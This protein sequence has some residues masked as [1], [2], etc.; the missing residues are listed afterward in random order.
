MCKFDL[1]EKCHTQ[2]EWRQLPVRPFDNSAKPMCDRSVKA[3]NSIYLKPS[4]Q[5]HILTYDSADPR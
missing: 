4:G 1:S 2:R 5:S 3:C